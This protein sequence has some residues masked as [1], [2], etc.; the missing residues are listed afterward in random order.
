M[1]LTGISLDFA[2]LPSRPMELALSPDRWIEVCAF[3]IFRAPSELS[4]QTSRE[5]KLCRGRELAL[6]P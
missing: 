6:T 2:A 3:G 1:R 5:V 4:R